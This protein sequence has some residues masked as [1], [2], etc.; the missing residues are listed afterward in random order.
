[1]RLQTSQD[2]VSP[3]SHLIN[4]TLQRVEIFKI[5][6]SWT[7]RLFLSLLGLL[8]SL[9][10]FLLLGR[11]HLRPLQNWLLSRW[12]PAISLLDQPLILDQEVHSFLFPWDSE[13][14]LIAGRRLSHPSPSAHLMTDASW[15]GWGGVFW[16]PVTFLSGTGLAFCTMRGY[17]E[18]I[19]SVLNLKEPFLR[20]SY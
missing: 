8:N 20:C 16:G 17:R 1:M 18:A 13:A 19:F 4:K 7:A 9:A 3:A 11:L 12:R 10:D 2:R 14:E 5:F 15:M 6:P